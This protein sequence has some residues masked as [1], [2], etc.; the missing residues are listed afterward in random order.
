M[1]KSVVLFIAFIF[2]THYL[3][4]QTSNVDTLRIVPKKYSKHIDKNKKQTIT[5]EELPEKIN[6]LKFT[7]AIGMNVSHFLELNSSPGPDKKNFSGTGAIDLGLNYKKDGG[8]LEMTNE[9][10]WM[11]NVQKAGL[12]DT[13]HI[14][15]VNDDLK[16]L[17]DYSVGLTRGN[18]LSINLIA[19]AT[20]SVFTIY[21]GD[22]FNDVNHM[23]KIQAFLSPYEVILSPGV[24]LQPDNYLRVSVSPYSMSLYGVDN[25]QIANTGRY[26]HDS[27]AGGN[28][29]RFVH[30]Q[31]GAEVNIWYDRQIGTWLEVQYRVS[32]SSDYFDKI[33]K[34]GLLDG[35]FI[36]KIKL[37][38]DLYLS[39]R[40]ELKGDFSEKPFKPY[41]SQTILL[42]FTKSL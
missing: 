17:H 20:T 21:D 37:F 8:R 40:A 7:F 12:A 2:G 36:T 35:L 26:T 41:Y 1:K 13:E 28:Y 24:K 38:K 19:K 39:H 32:I 3:E 30:K 16:T 23:G 9:A 29:V 33:G 42:S 4:A 15:R 31:L 25:Q 5:P 18:K 27:D 11:I 34:N 14:Q 6:P 22:Y 10:H